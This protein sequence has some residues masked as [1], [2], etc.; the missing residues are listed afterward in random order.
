MD[1]LH[2]KHIFMFIVSQL[3]GLEHTQ[4]PLFNRYFYLLENLAW[5][6]SFNICLDLED[7]Q[8]IFCNLYKLIFSIVSDSHSVKVKNFMLDMM[9]P[10]ITE[11]DMVSQ[12][13]L[14]V[15]LAQVCDYL[16]LYVEVRLRNNLS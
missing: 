5:V 7:N 2:L 6:K 1:P 3:R 15:I 9:C 11:A 16:P 12:E 14:D 4:S 8:E 10:L 13:L